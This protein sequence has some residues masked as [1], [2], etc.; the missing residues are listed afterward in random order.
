MVEFCTAVLVVS[1]AALVVWTRVRGSCAT[2]SWLGW[3]RSVSLFL[4]HQ[5]IMT[6][7]CVCWAF[8]LKLAFTHCAVVAL[9]S[10][11]VLAELKDSERIQ[12]KNAAEIRR[13]THRKPP[14]HHWSET[15]ALRGGR[16]LHSDVGDNHI[17][18]SYPKTFNAFMIFPVVNKANEFSSP[19]RVYGSLLLS[20]LFWTISSGDRSIHTCNI[21][22]YIHMYVYRNKW[23]I[24]LNII[25]FVFMFSSRVMY[26]HVFICYPYVIGK[27]S[28]VFTP[29]I[30]TIS[31]S[32][33][34]IEHR[35]WPNQLFKTKQKSFFTYV[36]MLRYL[37]LSKQG[38]WD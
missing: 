26:I 5:P 25:Y 38:G 33:N 36:H 10:S 3:L 13:L 28:Q 2:S 22:I 1:V 34:H 15:V 29:L 6:P 7:V 24:I 27:P 9:W 37:E 17:S 21:H 32:K 19:T 4:L 11:T 35:Q 30:L 16:Y 20:L 12:N 18:Q 23:M 14:P 8:C 31:N